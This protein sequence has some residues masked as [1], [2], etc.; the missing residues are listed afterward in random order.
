MPLFYRTFLFSL[1]LL[2]K[3]IPDEQILVTDCKVSPV[4]IQIRRPGTLFPLGP[5]PEINLRIRNFI[6]GKVNLLKG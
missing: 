1:H 2:L 3:N 6:A 4:A 5:G